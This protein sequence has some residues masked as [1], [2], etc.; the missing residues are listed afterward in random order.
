M[1]RECEAMVLPDVDVLGVSLRH[2]GN[3]LLVLPGRVSADRHG[4]V[5][6]LPLLAPCAKRLAGSWYRAG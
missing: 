2:R 3:E 6:G 4:N 1:R 5:M